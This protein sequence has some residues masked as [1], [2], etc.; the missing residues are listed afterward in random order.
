MKGKRM[1]ATLVALVMLGAAAHAGDLA[2][3][4]YLQ[5]VREVGS[6]LL[7]KPDGTFDYMLAYGAA[8]YWAKGTWRT[9]NGAVIL[10]SDAGQPKAAFQLL[11]SIAKTVP[12]IRVF[13]LAPQG[14][15]VPN[16]DVTLQ[17]AGG[18]SEARTD[19]DGVAFFPNA[20]KPQTPVFR[21]RVYHF[22]SEPV[23]LNAAHNEF[24]FEINGEAITQVRFHDE[25]L[26]IEGNALLMRYWGEDRPM[27]YAKQ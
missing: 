27:R 19:S 22:E 1:K 25:R 4:Y 6:E 8:D 12:G 16:I 10:N 11:R 9:S 17:T 24:Y 13:V 20:G 15:P 23:E 21:I 2:G 18:P 14:R 5:N 26:T 3:H 7:L